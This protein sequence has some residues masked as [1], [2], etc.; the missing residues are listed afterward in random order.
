MLILYPYKQLKGTSKFPAGFPHYWESSK[1]DKLNGERL[2][3]HI[4]IAC[5]HGSNPKIYLAYEHLAS[6]PNMTCEVLYR[7]L[8][9]EQKLRKGK[10]PKIL[11]L[12]LDNCIREN[13]NTIVFTFLCWLLERGIFAHVYV[14]FLPVGHTHF[15]CDQLASRVG[16][17]LK[18]R[19]VTGFTDLIQLLKQCNS[20]RPSVDVIGAV[21]DIKKLFNPTGDCNFPVSTSRVRR[22]MGCCTKV[23]PAPAHRFFMKDTSPLHWYITKDLEGKVFLQSKL[24]CDEDQWSTQHY[25][26]TD[27]APRPDGRP[28]DAGTSGLRPSDLTMAPQK[29]L[30]PTR[31]KELANSIPPARYRVPADDWEEIS[32]AWKSLLTDAILEGQPVPN[33]GLFIGEEDNPVRIEDVPVDDDDS[34]M[35]IRPLSRVF[36]NSSRQAIDRQ[37]RKERGRAQSELVVGNMIA[38]TVHYTA[39]TREDQKSDFWAG[40]ILECDRSTEQVRI[41]QYHTGTKKNL[42]GRT[43]EYKEWRGK[44]ANVWIGVDRVLHTFPA[45]T[46]QKS[47][48][49]ADDRRRIQA[50]LLLPAWVDPLPV[51]AAPEV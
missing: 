27:N 24:I 2:K 46:P 12:Q 26:W 28:F 22:C 10:L 36:I 5:V 19:N 34:P 35:C 11:Y 23:Q 29:M 3:I 45:L 30:A 15:D 6:D 41:L 1:Q 13:K 40:K 25:P 47:L 33:N 21:I 9:G 31:I 50:A 7:T 32:T 8:I 38:Y 17:L 48:V 44:D 49:G 42:R 37:E 4:E 51:D 20:P 16:L 14:S 43:A 18:Y 39:D